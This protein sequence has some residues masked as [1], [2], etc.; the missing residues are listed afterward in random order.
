MS[1]NKHSDSLLVDGKY[2]LKIQPLDTNK[3]KIYQSPQM[4]AGYIQKHPHTAIF[5]GRVASGKSNLLGNMLLNPLMYKGYFDVI[6]L[7]A[8]SCDDLFDTLSIPTKNIHTD[9]K[10]WDTELEKIFKKQQADIKK[11][12]I[13]EADR[14]LVIMDDI[15]NHVQFMKRS[16]W[17]KK[18]FVSFRQPGVTTW[19][20]SQSW[21]QVPR[22]CRL[23]ALVIYY[24]QGTAS[25]KNL[26]A[27]E[28]APSTMNDSQFK[29]LIDH[30]T[31]D[32]YSFLSIFTTLPE[33]RR[34]RK[35]L[36]VVLQLR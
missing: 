28:Y 18:C 10:Q 3:N 22:V 36:D 19:L 5:N 1:D 16:K 29:A 11:D 34:F 25:E 17:F 33:R 24:F 8:G 31:T 20:C 7:F 32:D 2:S 26:L 6:H 21:T 15:L 23:N 30:A 9:W 4:E 14:V 27:E 35:N 12:S 13:M